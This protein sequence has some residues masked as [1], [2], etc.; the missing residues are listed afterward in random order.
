MKR[1]LG[2]SIVIPCLN[3]QRTIAQ[4][5]RAAQLCLTNVG[6]PG[7]VIVADN[8]SLDSS[9]S[10]AQ[11]E[12]ARVVVVREPGYGSALNQGILQ[13]KYAFV[14]FA[15]ADL[16]YPFVEFESL[17]LPLLRDEADFVL[18]SRLRGRVESQA[19]PLLNRYLGTPV[20]SFCIRLVAGQRVSD[21]NSGMRVL[22]RDHYEQLELNCMGM[23][24]ASEMLIRAAQKSLRFGEVPITFKKDE[25]GR[26]SHLRRW[27]DGF[28]HL[29]FIV[30]CAPDRL[31]PNFGKNRLN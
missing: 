9:P 15:D 12:G 25:R 21:C 13:A 2:F 30:G 8:G 27:R 31:R 10:L 4:A 29:R 7:E 11:A 16:S 17:L 28:R 20:L 26:P 18:G 14:G 22:R 23:E 6:L 3:E 5:V 19:M 1:P 24:Y